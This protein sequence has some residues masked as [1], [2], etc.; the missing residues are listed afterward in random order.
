AC[1][2]TI[3]R[4]VGDIGRMV[5]EFSAFARMP[6]PVMREEDLGELCRQAIFLQRQGNPDIAYEAELPA[7]AFR[8]RC[9]AR[10]I[11]QALTNLLKNAVESIH[12]AAAEAGQDPV[13]SGQI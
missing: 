1:T 10:Q 7:A 13:P 11:G 3:V 2:E 8:F 12:A 6:A 4:Q 5:D 9:D